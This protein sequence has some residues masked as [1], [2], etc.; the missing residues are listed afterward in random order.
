MAYRPPDFFA[1]EALLSEEERMVAE[2]VRD[3]VSDRWM[4]LVAEHYRAGSFPTEV[5]PELA[6]LGV[7]GG[8]LDYGD[9]PRLNN[10]AYGP[11]MQ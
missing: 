3:W 11:V 10:V 1:I 6:E 9:F 4:P 2:A 8:N 7:L 5:I